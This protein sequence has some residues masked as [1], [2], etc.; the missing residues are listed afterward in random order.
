MNWYIAFLVI[1]ALCLVLGDVQVLSSTPGQLKKMGIASGSEFL[2]SG[3]LGFTFWVALGGRLGYL[4]GLANLSHS[5]WVVAT[6]A[7]LI[8]TAVFNTAIY[9]FKDAFLTIAIAAGVAMYDRD[10]L[11]RAF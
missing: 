5:Q 3:L 1:I 4:D 9:G 6:N 7:A 8:A 2:I 11:A 10:T